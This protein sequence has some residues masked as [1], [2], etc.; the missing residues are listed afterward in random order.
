MLK[1][2]MSYGRVEASKQVRR[3]W[4]GAARVRMLGR[5]EGGGGFVWLGVL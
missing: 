5:G 3:F 2:V 1:P 4:L